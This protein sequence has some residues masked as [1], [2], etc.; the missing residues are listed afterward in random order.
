MRCDEC[1]FWDPE[2][3][4]IDPEAEPYEGQQ[5]RICY[6]Y[7]PAL[8]GTNPHNAGYAQ[9]CTAPDHWCGEAKPHQIR[10]D[11]LCHIH[12]EA[13]TLHEKYWP[14]PEETPDDVAP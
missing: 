7:P 8:L 10:G 4:D 2:E 3:P 9:P 1:R 14:T 13:L 5:N 12:P 6:R 11:S